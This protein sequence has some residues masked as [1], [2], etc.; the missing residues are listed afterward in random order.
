M[1]RDLTELSGVVPG[2]SGHVRCDLS[3]LHADT[4]TVGRSVTYLDGLA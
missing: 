4:C 1:V 2:L 3:G